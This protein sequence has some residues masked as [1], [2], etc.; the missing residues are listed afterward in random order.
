MI[1]MTSMNARALELDRD[2]RPHEDHF[3]FLHDVSWSDYERILEVRGDHSAPR[4]AYLEG[5]L[6]I[7]SPS[8]NHEWIKSVIGSLVEVWC[9]ERGVEFSTFGSWT[10]KKK[11]VKRGVE[12]D[13]CYV[14]GERSRQ[15]P[16]PHL[17]IEVI[18][19]SGGL[20]KLEIYRKLEV[21]EVWIWRRGELTPY[22]LEGESYEAAAESRV[23][24]GIDLKQ[25]AGL[26]DQPSTSAAIRS[27]R[28][29]L[30]KQ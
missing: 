6:E 25:L 23:L 21:A 26:V 2:D 14:F 10:V 1:I 16:R 19:T 13:E 9:I 30:R 8:D 17:A 24:P 3:V 22:I 15:A 18:W 5:E 4:I 11:R 7:M 12:P 20:D 29:R 28:D 27:Y